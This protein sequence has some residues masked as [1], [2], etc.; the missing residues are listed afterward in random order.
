M[1]YGAALR[2][3]FRA[4]FGLSWDDVGESVSWAD[5]VALV[6]GLL[7]EFGSQLF[8]AMSGW[9]FTASYGELIGA[10]H[11]RAFMKS[12]FEEGADA[13]PFPWSVDAGQEVVSAE[14]R[15]I[16]EEYLA[17]HTVIRS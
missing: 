5:A 1:E 15:R 6:A 7:R 13:V 4:R 14:E 8:S 16:A 10:L 3:D 17:K 2:Y 11:Y 12:A 9:A